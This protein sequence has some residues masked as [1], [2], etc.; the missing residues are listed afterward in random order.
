MY[1]C[2]N[3]MYSALY[4]SIL[5]YITDTFSVKV[6]YF[7]KT[8][9]YP[10]FIIMLMAIITMIKGKLNILHSICIH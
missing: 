9:I 1:V 6:K 8:L 4:I 7:L 5:K 2:I 10:E 3:S